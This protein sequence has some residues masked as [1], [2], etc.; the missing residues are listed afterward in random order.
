MKAR[1]LFPC[2]RF[3]FVRCWRCMCSRWIVLELVV[4]ALC[5]FATY[6]VLA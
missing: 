3:I 5:V 1:V 4:T 6:E 2:I